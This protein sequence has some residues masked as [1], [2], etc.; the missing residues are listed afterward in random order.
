VYRKQ[1]LASGREVPPI[2][3]GTGL[4]HRTASP[5]SAAS[6]AGCHPRHSTTCCHCR[7]M[8][9][10]P[11]FDTKTRQPNVRSCILV[12]SCGWL[13]VADAGRV[14]IALGQVTNLLVVRN[15]LHLAVGSLVVQPAHERMSESVSDES[16][17]VEI[18]VD[19]P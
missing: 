2:G 1:A 7:S 12:A 11:R 8:A 4:V 6:A 18:Y 5:P 16:V 3:A 14:V 17:T 9:S 15:E 13:P 19:F 10:S